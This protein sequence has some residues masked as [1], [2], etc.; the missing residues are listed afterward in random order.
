MC[1]CV[2]VSK[3][4]LKKS[5]LSSPQQTDGVFSS[6]NLFHFPHYLS[7]LLSHWMACQKD[8]TKK[9]E[10]KS[11]LAHRTYILMIF[12][13]FFPHFGVSSLSLFHK[14]RESVHTA[15]LSFFINWK[16]T[17]RSNFRFIFLQYFFKQYILFSLVVAALWWW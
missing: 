11:H 12:F 2:C 13:L 1:V 7:L 5:F 3:V 14:Y 15:F 16:W 4:S 10:R 6:I 8:T 17:V 9:K